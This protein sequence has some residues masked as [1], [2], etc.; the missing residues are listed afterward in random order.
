MDLEQLAAWYADNLGLEDGASR[1]P[2][3]ILPYIFRTG[4]CDD[5]AWAVN[6]VTGW[7]VVRLVWRERLEG[8]HEYDEHH[9]LAR[10]PDG[11]YLHA[12]GWV[13]PED[14]RYYAGRGFHIQEA[15][16]E[17]RWI[18]FE[19]G[20]DEGL[21]TREHLAGLLLDALRVL[22]WEPFG[23]AP[24]TDDHSP[25]EWVRGLLL[26]DQKALSP[27]LQDAIR[28]FAAARPEL[29]TR[30]GAHDRC[31]DAS[32]AFVDHLALKGI[33]AGVEEIG[34]YDGVSHRAVEVEGVLV[35]WTARQYDEVAPWPLV[36]PNTLHERDIDR[37]VGYRPRN[38]GD[39]LAPSR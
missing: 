14:L 31:R 26:A 28:E 5:F 22:P 20:I 4:L 34:V 7:P 33:P 25:R 13:E 17:P 11:R 18:G 12:S 21:H 30:E 36:M 6:Q 35:D 10:A 39:A 29:A 8:G 15:K 27:A 37:A 2:E 38:P 32:S 23:K 3:E 9:A 1:A 24:F 19:S 16:P